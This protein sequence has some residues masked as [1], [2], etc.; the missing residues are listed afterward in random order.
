M[1]NILQAFRVQGTD[2]RIGANAAISDLRNRI[3]RL[4]GGNTR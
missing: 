3:A 1:W 2:E 4:E